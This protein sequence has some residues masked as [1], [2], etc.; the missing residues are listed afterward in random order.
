MYLPFGSSRTILPSCI[1]M[2][3][4]P[5]ES[6]YGRVAGSTGSAAVLW[7]DVPVDGFA[8]ALVRLGGS[9]GILRAFYISVIQDDVLVCNSSGPATCGRQAS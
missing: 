5:I 4:L 9:S 1:V 6:L 7:C 8:W 2:T 3:R